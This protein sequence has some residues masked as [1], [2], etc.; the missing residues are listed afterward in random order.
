MDTAIDVC[1]EHRPT[2]DQAISLATQQQKWSLLVQI[3]IDDEEEYAK[4]Q[5]IIER[6]IR[7]IRDRVDILK[8]YGPKILKHS[9][10]PHER[11]QL[12]AAMGPSLSEKLM[13]LVQ[14]IAEDACSNDASYEPG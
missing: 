6:E 10:A 2:R 1:R 3:Y 14:R 12:H 4:A 5:E 9:T 11:R 13:L 7:N 8:I